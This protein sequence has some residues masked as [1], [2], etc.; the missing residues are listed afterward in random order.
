MGAA[1]SA[2]G[3]RVAVCGFELEGVDGLESSEVKDLHVFPI[4]NAQH[5]G[6]ILDLHE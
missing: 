6:L 3:I 4:R 1:S 5:E 2:F